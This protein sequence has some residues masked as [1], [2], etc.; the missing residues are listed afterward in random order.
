ME[1]SAGP[2]GPGGT[3]R[4]ELLRGQV[5]IYGRE[6]WCLADYAVSVPPSAPGGQPA[7][8]WPVLLL[9]QGT[10]EISGGD[11]GSRFGLLHRTAWES[12]VVVAPFAPNYNRSSPV[13]AWT[14]S[15]WGMRVSRFNEDAV[16]HLLEHALHDLQQ[17]RGESFVDL[18]RICVSGFSLGG[19]AT[20]NIAARFGH[21]LAAVA[22]MACCGSDDAVYTEQG[23]WN[24]TS[25]PMRVYQTASERP[26]YRSDKQVEWV[27]KYKTWQREPRKRE[28]EIGG[29][30]VGIS[31]YGGDGCHAGVELW[32][33]Q[34]WQKNEEPNARDMKNHDVWSLVYRDEADYGLFSW[35]L[36]AR[37][38]NGCQMHK[39]FK[40][41]LQV[42]RPLP[43]CL[44]LG[45]P[46][47]RTGLWTSEVWCAGSVGAFFEWQQSEPLQACILHSLLTGR[48]DEVARV[49]DQLGDH[50]DADGQLKWTVRRAFGLGIEP[51]S[52]TRQNWTC[53]QCSQ[54]GVIG[55]QDKRNKE[56]F[57][58]GCWAREDKRIQTQRL[59]QKLQQTRQKSGSS[60]EALEAVQAADSRAAAQCR[61]DAT[62]LK[63]EWLGSAALLRCS[64]AD[65]VLAEFAALHAAILQRCSPV[66]TALDLRGVVLS[67]RHDGLRSNGSV[68]LCEDGGV[69]WRGNKKHGYWRLRADGVEGIDLKFNGLLHRMKLEAA[70][71][72]VLEEPRRHPASVAT[73]QNRGTPLSSQQSRLLEQLAQRKETEPV[74]ALIELCNMSDSLAQSRE[75]SEKWRDRLCD[76]LK[77]R[78]SAPAHLSKI[79]AEMNLL[80]RSTAVSARK[81][82]L[83][84]HDFVLS[85]DSKGQ[86]SAQL[87]DS[88]KHGPLQ[89]FLRKELVRRML[90]LVVPAGGWSGAAAEDKL[91][92]QVQRTVAAI[93]RLGLRGLA[94]GGRSQLRAAKFRPPARSPS[95]SG[96]EQQQTS[97]GQV[98]AT[99]WAFFRCGGGRL[100]GHC[101]G[102][103]CLGRTEGWLRAQILDFPVVPGEGVNAG[104]QAELFDMSSVRSRG[105][106]V[107]D[108]QRLPQ[109]Q[110]SVWPEVDCG[111]SNWP[112]PDAYHLALRLEGLLRID[113]PGRDFRVLAPEGTQGCVFI[114][115]SV[116][117][118]FQESQAAWSEKQP[119]TTQL[120]RLEFY[121]LANDAFAQVPSQIQLQ[122]R[123]SGQ[124][125]ASPWQSLPPEV[126]ELPAAWPL[127]APE[128]QSWHGRDGMQAAC[129]AP[130]RVPLS[131][132][133]RDT[134]TASARPPLPKL[135]LL[136]VRASGGRED[137]H[138]GGA[139]E[140]TPTDDF[141]EEFCKDH[142]LAALGPCYEVFTAFVQSSDELQHISEHWAAKAL[143][144]EA[145]AVLTFLWPTRAL[146]PQPPGFVTEGP[147]FDFM[148]RMER[149]G[150]PCRYPH[151]SHV[152][153][154]LAS[155]SWTA[156]LSALPA[157]RVPPTCRISAAAV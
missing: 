147:L 78:G 143:V 16:L 142:V 64:C 153:H 58:L 3:A 71:I 89:P 114:D 21:L 92:R 96:K 101:G 70:G 129:P 34:R 97:G 107:A 40:F 29:L 136:L 14:D 106:F 15:G 109:L 38:P 135:S 119:G 126:W 141:V 61:T 47:Q 98:P 79:N 112:I 122:W 4:P 44:K 52:L 80:T 93:C 152:Y 83:F 116:R 55:W 140:M 145:R 46:G 139:G 60:G 26:H 10:G 130:Q 27:G 20:W 117:C 12:F 17:E 50:V 25:L 68:E 148:L 154:T 94:H 33:I 13:L 84:P 90:Q 124:T 104:L 42:P 53:S 1:S 11:W 110:K 125:S 8:G 73:P 118:R 24:L 7:G 121:F 63:A 87:R 134:A 2:H 105:G 127:V 59:R 67:W 66:R 49:G 30:T 95:A 108:I 123:P 151:S 133:L 149:A 45:C 100:H 28:T 35:L 157:F 48:V 102:R 22:P 131:F 19:E 54:A 72:L 86:T 115:G 103:P 144:G 5:N 6:G 62:S 146:D 99:G 23:A 39:N 65:V 18:G 36:Q 91:I 132:V 57:C 85:R 37:N 75:Q 51:G 138:L 111:S 120:L 74:E 88:A 81:L 69:R 9:L 77:A 137:A 113:G 155:K 76:Y 156:H 128:S 41:C 31:A 150:L 32:E 82:Q 43:C 56:F